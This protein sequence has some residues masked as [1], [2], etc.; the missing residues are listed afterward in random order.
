MSNGEN[1]GKGLES[2]GQSIGKG[3][4]EK[5]KRDIEQKQTKGILGEYVKSGVISEEQ[6][7]GLGKLGLPPELLMQSIEMLSTPS[8]ED[9]QARLSEGQPSLQPQISTPAQVDETVGMATTPEELERVR[10]RP[11]IPAT[12][13]VTTPSAPIF[14]TKG[15]S[16]KIRGGGTMDIG[17]Y[18]PE[19]ARRELEQ[20]VEEK[21]ALQAID[22]TADQKN[23]VTATE[24]SLS[25]M[26][27]IEQ[28][29]SQKTKKGKYQFPTGGVLTSSKY[30]TL[31]F[32]ISEYMMAR[33]G[34]TG[35]PALKAKVRK[36]QAEF[37]KAQTGAQRGFKEMSFLLPVLPQLEFQNNEQ[38]L[39]VLRSA[40]EDMK[41]Y[42]N[43]MKKGTP[44]KNKELNSLKSKYGL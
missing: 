17:I 21:Q 12:P 8:V 16:T 11:A 4:I 32:G 36:L 15:M 26:D 22:I 1:I 29:L 35:E 38:A 7:S 27:N 34:K 2:L 44:T 13:P 20:K 31:P 24:N 3:F 18:N 28:A 43:Q 10:L 30:G 5:R 37:I 25:I 9:I 40:K 6:A 19:Q 33:T 14:Y 23:A 41:N 42:L 39:E